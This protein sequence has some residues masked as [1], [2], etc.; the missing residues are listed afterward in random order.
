MTRQPTTEEVFSKMTFTIAE[1]GVARENIEVV[2]IEAAE[3]L[4]AI[5]NGQPDVIFRSWN[6]MTEAVNYL[7]NLFQ[8]KSRPAMAA[9]MKELEEEERY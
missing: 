4:A 6:E 1:V 3:L 5:A 8:L 2:K 7:G 9:V